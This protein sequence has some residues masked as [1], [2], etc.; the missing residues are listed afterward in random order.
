MRCESVETIHTI[1]ARSNVLL[2]VARDYLKIS[3]ARM[4]VEIVEF[5]RE[6]LSILKAKGIIYDDLRSA[7]VPA[8]DR[9]EAGFLFDVEA[10]NASFYGRKAAGWVLSLLDPRATQSLRCGDLLSRDQD[11]LRTVLDRH[12]VSARPFKVSESTTVFCIYTNQ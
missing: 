3:H 1:N 4:R 10:L 12:L 6:L 7:L 9:H 8:T 2:E 11:F 5:H